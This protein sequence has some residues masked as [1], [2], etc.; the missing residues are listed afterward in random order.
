MT[1]ETNQL[2]VI[3][4]ANHGYV[5]TKLPMTKNDIIKI[6][7]DLNTSH[8]SGK[9]VLEHGTSKYIETYY[10]E[11]FCRQ[12]WLNT[13]NSFV[14]RHGGGT[15]LHWWIDTVVRHTIAKKFNGIITDDGCGEEFIK[16]EVDKYS[17]YKKYLIVR[18]GKQWRKKFG[19]R[20]AK[21]L[22][23]GEL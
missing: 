18:F 17:S 4:M 14:I 10:K 11:E 2:R 6:L 22:L 9:L 8:F 20:T 12:M 1:N 15:Q 7:E 3:K 5:K 19:K 16:E 23:K 21:L 13:K